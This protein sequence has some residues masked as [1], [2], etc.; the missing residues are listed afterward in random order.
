MG[1]IC[2]VNIGVVNLTPIETQRILVKRI[3]QNL[4]K[5]GSQRWGKRFLVANIDVWNHQ[6]KHAPSPKGSHPI[7]IAKPHTYGTDYFC[8][9]KQ[10]QCYSPIEK[11]QSNLCVQSQAFPQ[12]WVPA[13]E[14]WTDFYP[15]PTSCL[16]ETLCLHQTR[17]ALRNK[18]LYN[19]SVMLSTLDAVY[20]THSRIGI[21]DSLLIVES[22]VWVRVKI[23]YQE[24]SQTFSRHKYWL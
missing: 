16:T 22:Y 6:N 3:V 15:V 4:C 10:N 23:H 8:E 2:I 17:A 5:H 7:F 13:L 12:P 19:L 1:S 18:I 20:T 11:K 14:S 9:T 24:S 21:F